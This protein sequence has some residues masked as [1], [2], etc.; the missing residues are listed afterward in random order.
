[1]SD[2]QPSP[3]TTCIPA[4]ALQS[5]C[6]AVFAS[7]GL[8]GDAAAVSADVLVAADLRGIPSHGV[9]RLGRYVNGLKTG[10]MLPGAV[11][12]VPAETCRQLAQIASQQGIEPPPGLG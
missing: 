7:L 8:S 1:M 3:A 12:T 4:E 10:L 2:T 6:T 5:F 11:S 9:A